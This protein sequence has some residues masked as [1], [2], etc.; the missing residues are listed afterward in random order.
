MGF[1]FDLLSDDFSEDELFGEILGSDD[2]AIFAGGAACGEEREKHDEYG[3]AR[4]SFPSKRRCKQRLYSAFLLAR[5]QAFLQPA[6]AY[7]G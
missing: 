7:V 6:E 2:D 4:H 1:V 5:A 3:L